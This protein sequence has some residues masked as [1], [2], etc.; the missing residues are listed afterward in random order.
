MAQPPAAEVLENGLDVPAIARIDVED[1]GRYRSIVDRS[2]R[3]NIPHPI[4]QRGVTAVPGALRE[5]EGIGKRLRVAV[6]P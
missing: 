3:R 1:H 6:T 2:A 5:T 4:E